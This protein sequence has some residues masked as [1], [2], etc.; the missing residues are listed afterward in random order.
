MRQ[1]K[2]YNRKS[3][4]ILFSFL[5]NWDEVYFK[6]TGLLITSS[7][8]LAFSSQAI[9]SQDFQKTFEVPNSSMKV[10]LQKDSYQVNNNGNEFNYTLSHKIRLKYNTFDPLLENPDVFINDKLK[11][12]KKSLQKIDENNDQIAYIV[13]FETQA[14]PGY[15]EKIKILG[16][17]VYSPIPDNAM[18]IVMNTSVLEKVKNLPFVRWVGQ[19]QAAYK[20]EKA[21]Q[22]T[23]IQREPAKVYCSILLHDKSHQD[24]VIEF[25]RTIGG[26]V[27]ENP[28]S[29]RMVALLDGNQLYDVLNLNEVLFIDRATETSDDMDQVREIAGANFVETVAGYTG[30]GVAGEACDDGVRSSHQEFIANPIVLHGA[31]FNSGNSDHGTNVAS[32]LFSSGVFGQARG[33]LPNASRPIFA[34]RYQLGWP[35][36]EPFAILRRTHI[37][38]LVDPDGSYR[39]VF[40]TNSWG[41]AQTTSYTTI[42]AEFD[43][44]LFDLDIVVTQ[45]QSNEGNRD[46]RPEAWAKNIVSVG[47]IRGE[48]SLT[49]TDDS[50]SSGASIGPA[51]DGRIK[52]D[53]SHFYDGV[54]SANEGSDS[55]Y[56]N[57]GGTSS[58]TPITAGLFGLLHQMWANGIFDG[59]PGKNGDV[60]ENRPHMTTA[61]AILINLAY[62]YT[63]NGSFHDLTRIHQGWGFPDIKNVYETARAYGWKLPILIDESQIINPL[64]IHSYDLMSDGKQSL[65]A[66][67]VYADPKGNPGAVK[68]LINNLSLKLTSPSNV[69][70]WGNYGLKNNNWSDSGGNA[71]NLNNVENAF[72]MEPELGLWK[73]EVIADEI[74]QDGHLET[75][76]IDADYAL[77]ATGGYIDTPPVQYRLETTS[78][79][80]AIH[81]E[82][83]NA[84]TYYFKDVKVKLEAES[85]HGWKFEKWQGDVESTGNPISVVMDSDK[86][87]SAKFTSLGLVV[88]I[89]ET[90]GRTTTTENRRANPFNMP[91]DGSITSIS[92]Y[93]NGGRGS[94]ILGVY[95]GSGSI[96]VNRIGITPTT[97]VSNKTGWQTIN[98]I[99]PVNVLKNQTI[100]LAWVYENNPGIYFES[101]TPGRVDAGVSWAGGM[102]E[103]WGSTARQ[104]DNIYSIYANYID[105]NTTD[106]HEN[107]IT[108]PEKYELFD[109]Y[110]NPFNPTT[111]LRYSLPKRSYVKLVVFDILGRDVETIF[112]GKKDRG[113]YQV[114]FNANNLN[115][116]VYF[117]RLFTSDVVL[118][119]KLIL[120]K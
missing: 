9:F 112:E 107:R 16:G 56:T 104:S 118:V 31:S 69:V 93:H 62:Q 21:L 35:D 52:P 39:A 7:F 17:T 28:F 34:S 83:Q 76:G 42:S 87:I 25:I 38:Q 73:I 57:F 68:Q 64:E 32:I 27:K 71:D 99:T 66:T 94:M 44:I 2:I 67:L 78:D 110:P 117:Y 45:S 95:D 63:F 91:E 41:H 54:F 50:W 115:S 81:F 79:N 98:L 43:E 10:V 89:T 14:F 6:W 29:S 101:G 48:N 12:A 1:N 86:N 88:G 77:V 120:I 55:D 113:L 102:P 22:Q 46:S 59:S 8:Y 119:K 105:D 85:A 106:I 80:G 92:M 61:K 13:Q 18:V 53:L 82:P 109:A 72:V 20:L 19:F 84:T 26:I 111:T 3:P 37:R 97:D 23:V 75:Q 11:S 116:G 15:Q 60:F 24:K 36:G 114:Q 33:L 65:K 108:I 40:Q 5:K 90:L 100:F 30:Q 74:I 103:E 47:G 51:E 70:Y 58:A 96:P 4:S 49:R